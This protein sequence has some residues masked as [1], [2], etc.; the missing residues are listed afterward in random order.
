MAELLAKSK[1]YWHGLTARNLAPAN[2]SINLKFILLHQ[3]LFLPGWIGICGSALPPGALSAIIMFLKP[4]VVF[5][6]LV[7]ANWVTGL[8]TRWTLP[9]GRWNLARQMLWKLNF[10]PALLKDFCP[11]NRLSVLNFRKEA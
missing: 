10:T 8:A 1:K 9:I 7:T 3:K 2:I 5:T 4:G 11:I 6:I